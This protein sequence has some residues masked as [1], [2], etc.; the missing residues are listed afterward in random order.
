M[1]TPIL[2]P[3]RADEAPELLSL[4]SAALAGGS[5]GAII[6][7][8]PDPDGEEAWLHY[9]VSTGEGWVAEIDGAAAGFGITV[10]RGATRW[11]VSLFV[12]PAYQRRGLGRLLLDQLWPPGFKGERAT[13]VDAASRPAM[14]LYLRAGLT[15]RLSVLAFEGQPSAGS[16]GTQRLHLHDDW[17]EVAGKVHVADAAAFAAA[18]PTDHAHWAERGFAF[19]SLWRDPGEWLGYARW[20]SSGRLGPV[21]LTEGV[22]WPAAL[23]ALAGEAARGGLERLRLMVPAVNEPALRWCVER[24]LHYQGMEILLATRLPGEWNRCLIHRAGLP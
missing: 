7:D 10:E 1:G 14:S 5:A 15:P 4:M 21:V 20:S 3:G 12:Q 9:L 17:K 19:R 24:G 22:D 13:L 6:H 16:A 18:R 8:F 23:E 11:L 2:R